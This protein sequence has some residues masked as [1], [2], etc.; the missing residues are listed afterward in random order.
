MRSI[1]AR[2]SSGVPAEERDALRWIAEELVIGFGLAATRIAGDA[3]RHPEDVFNSQLRERMSEGI[4]DF[5]AMRKLAATVDSFVLGILREA[6]VPPRRGISALGAFE[7]QPPAYIDPLAEVVARLAQAPRAASR[8]PHGID[9]VLR[10]R[11]GAPPS[12]LTAQLIRQ[13]HAFLVRQSGLPP[14]LLRPL[15]LAAPSGDDGTA[16]EGASTPTGSPESTEAAPSD[17][18]AA[19][20]AKSSDPGPTLFGSNGK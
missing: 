8:L 2:W 19:P 1:G 3:Y 10:R 14:D 13:V 6:G 20:D 17:I 9:A 5:A 12:A 16:A 7:P 4:A 18:E 15:D 11:G